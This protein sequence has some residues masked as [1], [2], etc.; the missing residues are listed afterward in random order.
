MW[1]KIF[2]DLATDAEDYFDRLKTRLIYRLSDSPILIQPYTGYGTPEKFFIRGRVMKNRGITR[3]TDNDTVWKNLVNMYRRFESDEIPHARVRAHF[4]GHFQDITADEEG[5]FE[6]TFEPHRPPRNQ[7][8]DVEFELLGYPG[9]HDPLEPVRTAGYALIAPPDARVVVVSDLDDTVIQ[10]DV[11]N[12]IR[13]ARNTFLRNSR[14]R[15]PFEGVAA[16]YRALHAG[17]NPIYYVSGSPWNLYELLTDFFEIRGIPEGAFFLKDFGLT[18]S[19]LIKADHKEHKLKTIF[20]LMALHR[21]LPFVLIGDSGEHDPDI[22]AQVGERFP[23]RVRA[24]YIR[25]VTQNEEK[26]R[27]ILRTADRMKALG[28]D[29]LLVKDTVAAAEHAVIE[30]LIPESALTD[31]HL[32]RTEDK[33]EPESLEKLIMAETTSDD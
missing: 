19:Y 32:E 30:G 27:E 8:Y 11:V 20:Q 4:E 16:F 5:F 33:K 15:L 26:E 13:L 29:M 31:I 12:L 14:T 22:Y 10:S 1:K 6:V 23:Q 28:V 17:K 18:E 7:R 21:D 3:A 24:I 9:R 2:L 25:D